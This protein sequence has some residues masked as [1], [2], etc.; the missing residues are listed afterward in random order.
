MITGELKNRIDSLWTEF[1]T[2]GITNPLTVIE[3]ITF[4]MY[5]RMLDMAE[6]RDERM[7]K[8]AGKSFKPRFT[9]EEQACRWETWRHYG[10]EEMLPHA[11]DR[12][13]AHFRRLAAEAGDNP[14]AE[15]MKDAQLMIQKPSLLVKAVAMI[16]DLPLERGDTKGDLYEYLLGKL[17]TAG[18]NGQFRTPRH[19]IRMMVELMAPQPT[20]RICD[21]ACGTAGFLI[22]SYDYLLRKYSSPAGTHTEIVDGETVTLYSG[23]LLQE[24][25]EHVDTD[26][27]HAFDFDAKK[28]GATKYTGVNES[29]PDGW[30]GVDIGPESVKL[31]AEEIS[32]AKTVIWNGPMGVFEIKEASKGTFDIAEAMAANST[33]KN[34]IGG[35]DS[36]KAVKK[37]KLGDKMTFIST[38]GGASLE[39]LEGKV[40]PGVA[41]LKE[42]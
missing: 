34:I 3:Q 37:A 31:F 39:L 27:F 17:T 8:V 40:L 30:E 35:G 42:K 6:R 36:V 1:W 12:V 2:G 24:H 23:D 11:R 13:F 18:I 41:C 19:I 20:D 21:P 9:A 22:E 29:I 32:K 16:G 25:R 7:S 26:M 10:A 15:F 14:F 28:L 33:A 5:A 4:L 38:G